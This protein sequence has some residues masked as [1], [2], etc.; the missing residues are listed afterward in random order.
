[1]GEFGRQD[2]IKAAKTAGADALL[3][4]VNRAAKDQ[5]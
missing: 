2:A 4:A 1:M 5:H 3:D